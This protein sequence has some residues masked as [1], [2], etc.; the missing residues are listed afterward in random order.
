M[1][2]CFTLKSYMKCIEPYALHMSTAQYVYVPM[3]YVYGSRFLR[4][5][6]NDSFL[7]KTCALTVI[8]ILL[9]LT[10]SA[11]LLAKN[12]LSTL[13]HAERNTML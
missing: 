13:F 3:Q 1:Y 11:S 6:N 5:V 10:D 4:T 2:T 8:S 12:V 7:T 9:G